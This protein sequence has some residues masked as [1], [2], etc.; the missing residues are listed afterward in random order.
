[1]QFTFFWPDAN[2]WEGSDFVV[3]VTAWSEQQERKATYA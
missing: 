2:R 1:V 3:E